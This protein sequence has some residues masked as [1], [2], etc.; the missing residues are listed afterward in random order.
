MEDKYSYS[1]FI[2]K[3]KWTCLFIYLS[4]LFSLFYLFLCF[5]F[6]VL[7]LSLFYFVCFIYWSVLFSLFYLFL[8]NFFLQLFLS[9]LPHLCCLFLPQCLLA[10]LSFGS[11]PWLASWNINFLCLSCLSR[12]AS[13]DR[14][15]VDVK[16]ILMLPIEASS[17][18]DSQNNAGKHRLM[19]CRNT[20]RRNS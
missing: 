6:F 11:S 1:V 20:Q 5:I 19:L 7:F 4:V 18:A 2:S 8:F 3:Y 13:L 16:S 10:L 15:H 9:F 17:D 12:V 14:S